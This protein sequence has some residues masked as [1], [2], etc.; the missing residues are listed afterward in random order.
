MY[1]GERPALPRAVGTPFGNHR[2]DLL[3]VIGPSVRPPGD[4]GWLDCQLQISV[5]SLAG[6]WEWGEGADSG[7]LEL[8]SS[9]PLFNSMHIY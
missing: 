4:P 2:P 3:G 5:S 8:D 6:R 7:L 9:A 1:L